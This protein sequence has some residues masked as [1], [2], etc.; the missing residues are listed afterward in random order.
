M[1]ELMQI[2]GST[3]SLIGTNLWQ[4]IGHKQFPTFIAASKLVEPFLKI[5][6]KNL[7]KSWLFLLDFGTEQHFL[8]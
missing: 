7:C 1:N 2:S 5:H 8:D 6:A 4:S 3:Q